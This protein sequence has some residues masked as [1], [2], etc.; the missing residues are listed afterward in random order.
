V[1]FI[2][3]S[4]LPLGG[5]NFI[6]A[7][8]LGRPVLF[9]EHTFNFQTSSNDAVATGAALRVKDAD[10]LIAQAGRLLQTESE[11]Y[12]MAVQARTF[13]KQHQGATQRTMALIE[14]MIQG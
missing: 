2:G 13:S 5:Q 4:L 9:G 11:R 1:A 6:E 14:P 3:G 7:C 8:M 10:E 12:N